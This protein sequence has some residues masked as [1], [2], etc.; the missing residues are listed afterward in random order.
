MTGSSGVVGFG[1]QKRWP[2]RTLAANGRLAAQVV[3]LQTLSASDEF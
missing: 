3:G 1:L 2:F